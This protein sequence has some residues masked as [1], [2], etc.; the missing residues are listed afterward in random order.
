LERH[1]EGVPVVVDPVLVA[2]TGT[3]LLAPGAPETLKRRLLPPAR[4]ITP[5]LPEAEALAGMTI[6]DAAAMHHAAETLLTRC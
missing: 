1:A 4:L 3:R 5:N 6:G 2:T